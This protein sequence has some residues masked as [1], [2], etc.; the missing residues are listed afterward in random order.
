MSEAFCLYRRKSTK[1]TQPNTLE[2]QSAWADDV[3]KRR[4]WPR[5]ETYTDEGQPS[6][7]LNRPS[8]KR[9]LEDIAKGRVH[10]F[11]VNRHDRLARGTILQ[12]ILNF[13]KAHNCRVVMGDVPEEVGDSAD[14]IL[15]FLAGYDKY[16]LEL[17]R[18]RTVEALAYV[19][20]KN[21]VKV[22]RPVLGFKYTKGHLTPEPWV[23]DLEHELETKSLYQIEREKN[24]VQPHGKKM[25]GR[26][27]SYKALKRVADYAKAYR[28]GK[29]E[30]AIAAESRKSLNRINKVE[31]ERANAE[32]NLRVWLAEH[33]PPEMRMR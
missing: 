5:G 28:E 30:E 22:G 15:G 33:T 7:S 10:R 9:L 17:L 2:I 11:G 16:F 4:G 29:L 14:V 26:P 27:I 21:E 6:D 25:R 18:S 13:C 3:C 32:Q 31:V 12:S 20:E 23:K 24:F 19:K 8:L 1:D